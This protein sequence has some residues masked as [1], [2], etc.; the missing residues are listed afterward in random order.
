[1][2]QLNRLFNMVATSIF[3]LSTLGCPD[4]IFTVNVF[5]IEFKSTHNNGFIIAN[6]IAFDITTIMYY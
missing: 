3:G 4:V 2:L 6:L 1:M 5:T